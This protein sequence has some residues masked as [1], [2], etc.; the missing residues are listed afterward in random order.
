MIFPLNV[1]QIATINKLKTICAS[2]IVL[3]WKWIALN[4]LKTLMIASSIALYS[5]NAQEF[6]I[7]GTTAIGINVEVVGVNDV[8]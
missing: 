1:P 8:S 5:V 6:L 4:A 7:L 2:W 3:I